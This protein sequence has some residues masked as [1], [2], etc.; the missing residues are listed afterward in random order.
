MATRRADAAARAFARRS[1][2]KSLRG[3]PRGRPPGS[4]GAVALGG[5]VNASW[6]ARL[7]YRG[8]RLTAV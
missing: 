8:E 1:D 4:G 5:A 6:V 7:R 2:H 3:A